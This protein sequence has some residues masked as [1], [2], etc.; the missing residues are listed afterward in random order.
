MKNC[1]RVEIVV[2]KALARMM[3]EVLSQADAPG[4]TMIDHAMGR[5][6]RGERRGDDPTGASTNCVFIIACETQQMVDT[7]VEEVRPLL[8]Q[9]GGMCLVSEAKWVKH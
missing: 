6:D 4:Y 9:S 3:A 8:T 7:I 1:F 5:G 2:E